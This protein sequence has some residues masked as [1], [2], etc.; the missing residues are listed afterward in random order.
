MTLSL[1]YANEWEDYTVSEETLARSTSS[2]R[3][4]SRSA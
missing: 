3:S 2:T 1:T 4:S